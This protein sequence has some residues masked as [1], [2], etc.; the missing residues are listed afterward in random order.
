MTTEKELLAAERA[1]Q[2]LA[3]EKAK[4][5]EAKA[6]KPL[7]PAEA[8][9]HI[10][11]SSPEGDAHDWKTTVR[12]LTF[13]ERA[14][15]NQLAAQLANATFDTLPYEW[16]Q[17]LL[18]VATCHVMWRNAPDWF[19]LAIEQDEL[20]ALRVYGAVEAHR[21]RRFRGSGGQGEEDARKF[22]VV[23]S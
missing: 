17:Y 8:N 23:L 5:T 22:S 13:D 16:R 19:S 7:A 18:A 21:D 12:V 20:L 10:Q 15:V 11:W 4:A 3:E 1:K 14:S 6:T 2:A 9:L